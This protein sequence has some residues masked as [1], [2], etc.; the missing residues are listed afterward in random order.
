MWITGQRDAKNKSVTWPCLPGSRAMA[1]QLAVRRPL[2]M[3]CLPFPLRLG[4]SPYPRT[5]LSICKM[6]II[7]LAWC[8]WQ[9]TSPPSSSHLSL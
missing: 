4:K 1:R 7:F 6:G 9:D 8:P 3:P 5:C 2:L